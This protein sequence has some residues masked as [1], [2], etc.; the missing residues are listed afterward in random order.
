MIPTD[1]D[2]ADVYVACSFVCPKCEATITTRSPV[3]GMVVGRCVCPREWH[4]PVQKVGAYFL[5]AHQF[6]E[7]EA[8]PAPKDPPEFTQTVKQTFP[9]ET[10]QQTVKQELAVA[11]AA[12]T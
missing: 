11:D 12:S 5:T 1:S 6:E 10:A 9:A 7:A 8:D 3:D 4:I 2:T